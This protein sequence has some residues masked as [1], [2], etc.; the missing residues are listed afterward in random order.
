MIVDRL[1]GAASSTSP[2]AATQLGMRR[3]GIAQVRLELEDASDQVC[4]F[5]EARL[6]AW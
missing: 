4:P 5:Q 3:Q 2:S 6:T 1:P